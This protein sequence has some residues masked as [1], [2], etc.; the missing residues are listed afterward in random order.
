[1]KFNVGDKVKFLNEK[2]GG[3]VSRIISSSMVAVL[4]E[5][6]FEIPTMTGEII[7]MD[8]TGKSGSM[9]DEDFNVK[10]KPGEKISKAGN[11][12]ESGG[13]Q[14]E[15][16]GANKTDQKIEQLVSVSQDYLEPT[17]RQ[18][19]L[20]N[21][22]YRIKNPAGVY[23]VFVPHDQKWLVTG[24]IEVY[25]VNHSRYTILF[26]LFLCDDKGRYSG[27]DYDVVFAGNKILLD[28][29]EREQDKKWGKGILQ[30]MMHQE[31]PD[32]IFAPV[33]SEFEL[34]PNRFNNEENYIYSEFL[35]EK[36]LIVSIA[37]LSALKVITGHQELK[38]EAVP[39]SVGKA[40]EIMPEAIIARHQT[41]PREAV[42]DLHIEELVENKEG[43]SPNEVLKLQMD[44]FRKC[45]D[46]AVANNFRKVT[47]IHGVGNGSL[48]SA[49]I[50]KLQEYENME[51]HSASIAKF[52]VGAIDVVIRPLK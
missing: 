3:V 9:F 6:G 39:G 20:G 24:M 13:N 49:L 37:E 25:L 30:I 15:P 31:D 44:Y 29:F 22:S 45:I 33:N 12:N 7:K 26:S 28:T 14:E 35:E 8:A 52:G 27:I 16:A 48:R 43:L 40:R 11:N 36:A 4:V 1:M 41:A 17:D 47:F 2:G 34:K 23:L 10:W 32:K 51:N 50:K 46:S 5:A 21:F 42:V 19:L 18:S 38:N